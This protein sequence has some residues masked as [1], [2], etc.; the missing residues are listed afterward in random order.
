MAISAMGNLACLTRVMAP[1]CAITEVFGYFSQLMRGF[2][3]LELE[4]HEVVTMNGNPAQ[5]I[6]YVGRCNK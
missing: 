2:D 3:C 5:A 1:P 4:T 6:R